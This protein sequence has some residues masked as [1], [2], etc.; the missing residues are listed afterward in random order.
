MENYVFLVKHLKAGSHRAARTWA[1]G[2][3]SARLRQVKT[4]SLER[5]EVI[6]N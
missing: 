4:K 5:M 1:A 3:G 6:A 2:I